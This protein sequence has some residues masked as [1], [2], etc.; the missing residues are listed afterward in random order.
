MRLIHTVPFS[1]Q[2]IESYRQLVYDNITRGFK[3]LLDA[4]EDMELKVMEEHIDHIDLIENAR[5]LHEG[6]PFHA[7]Y[8][9]PLKQLWADPGVQRA[10]ERGNEAALPEK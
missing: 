8:L 2:E 9:E 7:E 1:T 5:D 4:M 6:E 3:Y 10:W